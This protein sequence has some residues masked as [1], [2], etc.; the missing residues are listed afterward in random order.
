MKWLPSFMN[1]LG[2]NFKS[3][4]KL[5]TDFKPWRNTT[6]SA[7][8]EKSLW[9]QSANQGESGISRGDGSC[10]NHLLRDD[11]GPQGWQFSDKLDGSSRTGRLRNHFQAPGCGDC[12]DWCTH[13]RLE[14][15]E[16]GQ[17]Y[18][19]DAKRSTLDMSNWACLENSKIESTLWAA[20]QG[21]GKENSG[22]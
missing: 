14:S 21:N 6:R 13:L 1:H 2:L 20:G 12:A 4:K 9:M 7:F 19:K 10:G 17:A 8:R 18:G 11:G 16:E 22:F 3:S 5:M 15:E